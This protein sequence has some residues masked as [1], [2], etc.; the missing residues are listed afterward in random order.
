M[1][2]GP[3]TSPGDTG[4]TGTFGSTSGQVPGYTSGS[5]NL[6]QVD[7][8]SEAVET[9]SASLLRCYILNAILF[10]FFA[11]W[12]PSLLVYLKFFFVSV[13]PQFILAQELVLR[14]RLL[15][16]IP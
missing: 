5:G 3:S 12:F 1:S 10:D 9:T 6:G 8:A 14:S 11:S 4:L 15:K 16:M 2:A 7:V 13:F